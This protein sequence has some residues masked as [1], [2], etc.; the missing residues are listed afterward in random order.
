MEARGSGGQSGRS[1]LP[2]AIAVAVVST[3][4]ATFLLWP[5]NGVIEPASVDAK[6]YFTAF[7]LD[8]AEDFRGV[9]RLIGLGGLVLGTGTLA[10]LA[11]RPPRRAIE[12]ITRRPILGAAV[13][14]AGISLLLVAVDLPLSAWDHQR[15]VDVGLS[16][17]K[18]GRL[19]RRPRQVGRDR[20]RLRR[21]RRRPGAGARAALPA[22]LVGPGRARG[23]R[24]RGD[25]DLA[26]PGRDRPDLQR[27]QE[28]AAGTDALRRAGAGEEGRGRRRRGLPR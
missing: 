4:A 24:V 8:R 26:V 13:A 23:G 22:P 3:G 16:T 12:R 27:L 18:L 7:Q 14:G 21:D 5:R 17:Q 20:R 15:A 2:L 10:L 25:H 11:W 9:Q 28:A 6:S 1:R 19:V